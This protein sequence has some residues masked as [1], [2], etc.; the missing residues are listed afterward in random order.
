[1]FPTVAFFIMGFYLLPAAVRGGNAMEKGSIPTTKEKYTYEARPMN[2]V[3]RQSK[4]FITMEFLHFENRVLYTS[5]ITKSGSMEVTRIA[6]KPDGDFIS[7]TRDQ[8]DDSGGYMRL[9]Q[10]WRDENKAYVQRYKNGAAAVKEYLLPG[11][12]RLAVDA[13]LLVLLRSF[14]FNENRAWKLFMV[15]FSQHSISVTVNQAAVEDVRVPAGNFTCYRMEVIVDLVIFHPKITY[16][17]TKAVPHF[18]VKHQGKRGPFT[19]SYETS[20]LTWN[21]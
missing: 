17:I 13:S 1:M 21:K 18:L 11:D 8:A 19:P 16:W 2:S 12:R 20:L 10:I 5:T 6:V 14:P 4:E 9:E 15:D 3:K 7:A